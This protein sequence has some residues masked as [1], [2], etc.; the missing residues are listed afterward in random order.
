MGVTVQVEA[1]NENCIE[2]QNNALW[3]M[4]NLINQVTHILFL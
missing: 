1:E 3:A 4:A 2:V